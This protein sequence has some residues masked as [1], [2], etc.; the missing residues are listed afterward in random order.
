MLVNK[1]FFNFVAYAKIAEINIWQS[2][3]ITLS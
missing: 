2:T 3:V 1:P